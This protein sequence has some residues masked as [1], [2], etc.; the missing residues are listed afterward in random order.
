MHRS[1]PP[2]IALRSCPR[3]RLLLSCFA[4]LALSSV[5]ATPALAAP[6]ASDQQG[7]SA[8]GRG[9]PGGSYSTSGKAYEPPD[10]VYGGNALSLHVPIQFGLTPNGF[11]PRGRIGLQGD[12]GAN[13]RE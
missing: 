10:F 4:L 9:G 3:L 8:T 1:T 2:S 6:P 7:P 5:F 11:I 13:D 12:L